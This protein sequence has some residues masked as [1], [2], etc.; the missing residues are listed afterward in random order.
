VVV[1]TMLSSLHAGYYD[2]VLVTMK[3]FMFCGVPKKCARK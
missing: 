3:S 1:M 2:R